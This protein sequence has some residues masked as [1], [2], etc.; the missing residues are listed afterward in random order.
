MF[1]VPLLDGE[2]EESIYLKN[3]IYNFVY[4]AGPKHAIDNMDVQ[5]ENCHM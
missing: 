3:L 1:K 4:D 2:P 5:N